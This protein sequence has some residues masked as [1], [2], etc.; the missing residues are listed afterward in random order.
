VVREVTP[1][2]VK[3]LYNG[4]M[5]EKVVLGDQVGALLS[6]AAAEHFTSKLPASNSLNPSLPQGAAAM[7]PH[8]QGAMSP[9]KHA[10]TP[11]AVRIAPT[12]GSTPGVAL[13]RSHAFDLMPKKRQRAQVLLNIYDLGVRRS[14]RGMNSALRS[15]G[16]GA[17]HAGVEVHGV[18][19][20]YG[21]GLELTYLDGSIVTD[22]ADIAASGFVDSSSG[23]FACEPRRCEVHKYRES[24][25]MGETDLTATAVE[26]LLERSFEDW[27]A[28]GYDLTRHN[29]CSFAEAFCEELGVGSLPPWVARLARTAAPFNDLRDEGKRARGATTA[30]SYEFGDMTR[31]VVR[32]LGER[33]RAIT[34][35]GG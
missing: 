34:H 8:N 10:T 11:H 6:P 19:W 30:E 29:C 31:G 27:A 7:S 15:F 2:G 1:A 23:I 17:Y 12:N 24:I 25:V 35:G 13:P 5:N 33:V 9:Q 26:E 22:P 20:S 16:A 14:V 4:Q 28:N 3:V 18:E 32:I 21:A